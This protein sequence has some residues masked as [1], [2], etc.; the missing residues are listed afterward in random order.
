MSRPHPGAGPSRER[1]SLAYI[2]VSL[3]AI[4]HAA[5]IIT[6]LNDIR[7]SL[8]RCINFSN[9]E[10][11]PRIAVTGCDLHVI[12]TCKHA[13]LS[14]D[15]T[16]FSA[17][18]TAA[19]C[20]SYANRAEEAETDAISVCKQTS[21]ANGA[22]L[23]GPRNHG[24]RKASCEIEIAVGNEGLRRINSSGLSDEDK[25]DPGKLFKLFKDQL[26]ISVNFRIRRLEFLRLRQHKGETLDEFVNRCRTKAK[27]CDF[28][29]EE[30]DER[31]I[32]LVIASTDIELFQRELLDQPKGYK[33]EKML[34]AGR[35]YE[36]FAAGKQCIQTLE[37]ASDTT[38]SISTIKP[39]RHQCG[40][41]GLSHPPRKCP[42]YKDTCD[43][44][45]F[46]GHW[47][48][49]CRKK[50]GDDGKRGRNPSR[51]R[52]DRRRSQSRGKRYANR[53]NDKCSGR[54]Y[55]NDKKSVN[56]IDM[57][58]Q[59]E[60]FT[61][62]PITSSKGRDEA[63]ACLDIKIPDRANT[64]LKLKID[65]G[66]QRNTLPVRIYRQMF[67]K[68]LNSDGYPTAGK[69]D[70]KLF[71]YNNTEITHYGTVSIPCRFENSTWT[72]TTFYIVDVS[73]PAIAGLP[74]CEELNI[75]T[76]HCAIQHV[77][78]PAPPV[79]ITGNE[80]LKNRYPDRFE[81]IGCF[82]G[83]V[84]LH[85]DPDEQP[86]ID[87]PR[88]TPIALREQ[89]K[90]ELDR[91]QN[92]GVIKRVEEP[93]E[94]VSSLAYSKKKDGS[95][96]ICLD[97]KHLNRALKRPHHKIPTLE[98]INHRF[99]GAKYF[100]KL[101]AKSGYWS[102]KLHPD[103]QLL[104]T[105]QTPFGRFCF[106]RLPFGLSVSQDIFQAKMDEILD[107]LEGVTGIADDI[108]VAGDT[109]EKHDQNLI[110]LM[111]RSVKHGLVLNHSKCSI[112]V[113][114][115]EF[116]GQIYSDQGIKPDP[117]KIEDLADMKVPESKQELQEFLGLLTYLSPFIPNLAEK[118]SVLRDLLKEDV[119]FLWEPH[120]AVAFEN[121]KK[122][123]SDQSTLK[124]PT[125]KRSETIDLDIRVDFVRF[126]PEKITQLRTESRNDPVLCE[127]SEVITNGWPETIK[128][129]PETIRPYWSMRDELSVENGIVL[130]GT[131]IVVPTSMREE[132]LSQL[133][134]G[135]LGIEKT[136]LRAR[137]TVYW[138]NI[139][140]DIERIVKTCQACQEELPSQRPEPLIPHEIPNRPWE[141]VGT[142]LFEHDGSE[143][144]IVADYYSKFPVI[145]KL[146]KPCP[147]SVV[148]TYT[149][150]IFAEYG[151]AR[152]VISDNG[153]HYDSREYRQ[154]ASDWN[155][156]H[157]TSSPRYPKSNGFVESSVKT[158]KAI[159][160]K[161]KKTGENIHL[162][163]LALRA[164]PIN[165]R[166]PSPGE[167]LR[168]Q[169][170]STPILTKIPNN[171]ADKED[172]RGNLERKQSDM[173]THYDRTTQ[174]LSQLA[175][176]QQ[177]RFQLQSHGPWI[178]AQ[179]ITKASEP[180]SYVLET[181]N[182][183]QIRR[184]RVHIRD[185]PPPRVRFA[186]QA[187]DDDYT[188]SSCHDPPVSLDLPVGQVQETTTTVPDCS[189]PP[190]I[191]PG[192]QKPY[193][194]RSGRVVKP[195][196]R[197]QS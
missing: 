121:L 142:D 123:I 85:V 50:N 57:N 86:H 173:K 122:T 159:M 34:E 169:K 89:I 145:R 26:K 195:N 138:Y 84:K 104:T 56:S 71:A 24:Q 54:S 9:R 16:D 94:W 35:K 10:H 125:T 161:A 52:L 59:V 174:N 164:T 87:P 126:T 103:S 22:G 140:R 175:E 153:P 114:S 68:R 112:K 166:L 109:E 49:Q 171:R 29:D 187:E 97:P 19:Y 150:S 160:T 93:T 23:L 135:H 141:I 37:Q 157:V 75:V 46:K 110:A 119:T 31:V 185:A 190:P 105:F 79:N 193:V 81:G 136:C 3:H 100:S 168:G 117:A 165:N 113:P 45:S 72:E 2:T 32:E 124:L 11:A 192:G 42:A 69:S 118:A 17:N 27:D 98:E 95:L 62:S 28:T 167:L 13:P 120:H 20:R 146:P 148:I 183:G 133:H 61:F 152:R 40:N 67:P 99:N 60:D 132:I 101:D 91:M 55:Q 6:R 76:M 139:R 25:N 88:K 179:V 92:M 39:Q 83:E 111:E 115:M 65:T 170:L 58:D 131:R 151:I 181:P 51:G 156:Q 163:L 188:P 149:Q 15:V 155:F 177:V 107:G 63:Y 143:W 137:D 197:Y 30:L 1:D 8:Y 78:V 96:R 178:P 184:N 7:Y 4:R 36:A 154:F 189:D 12:I 64:K 44:C 43:F 176:G 80:D 106:T 47:E 38:M 180:R 77:R 186:D 74:T 48:K 102:V 82:P 182:G 41:C 172:I 147:S 127:L 134:Y 194:S 66:A 90:S 158:V 196:P 18:D 70:I 191:D 116:F 108:G 128:T 21:D 144:L 53:K 5:P 129:L 130:K 162:A 33:I 14:D 73:G